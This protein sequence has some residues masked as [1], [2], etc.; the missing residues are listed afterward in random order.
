MAFAQEAVHIN[1]FHAGV[2]MYDRETNQI[3]TLLEQGQDAEARTLFLEHLAGRCRAIDQV[4][5]ECFDQERYNDDQ[6]WEVF[7]MAYRLGWFGGQN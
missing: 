4:V 7:A 3:I 2:A 1:L 6:L 5:S